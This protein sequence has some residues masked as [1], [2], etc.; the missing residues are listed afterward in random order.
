MLKRV[1]IILCISFLSNFSFSQ[2]EIYKRDLIIYF[3]DFNLD[4]NYFS[5]VYENNDLL[6]KLKSNDDDTIISFEFI[7]E[8]EEYSFFF[9]DPFTYNSNEFYQI[10]LKINDNRCKVM[11]PINA[12][13]IITD[14]QFINVWKLENGYYFV[15]YIELNDPIKDNVI[16]FAFKPKN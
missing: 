16:E 4:S 2:R 13:E 6:V 1:F 14:N 7:H 3:S 9:K 15:K 12:G 5:K 8:K 10:K 11:V